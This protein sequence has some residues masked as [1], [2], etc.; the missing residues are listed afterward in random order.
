M[1]V[2]HAGQKAAVVDPLYTNLWQLDPVTRLRRLHRTRRNPTTGGTD[3][4]AVPVWPAYWT[5]RTS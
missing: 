3:E 5:I 2:M 1:T 4:I